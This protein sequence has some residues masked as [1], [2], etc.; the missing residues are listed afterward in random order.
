M[1]SDPQLLAK[2]LQADVFDGGP[3]LVL[4]R[5]RQGDDAEPEAEAMSYLH[6][7][8]Y[9]VPRVEH[10]D[11]PD[12]LMERVEG[13][14]M[15]EELTKRPWTLLRH[16]HLLGELHAELH[17]L[18]VPAG[19]RE[20]GGGGPSIIH[21]D[22]HPDNIILSPNGPVVIDWSNVARSEGAIDVAATWVILATA[23]MPEGTTKPM[24]LAT[25][26]GRRTFLGV[27]RRAA[28]E[29][30]ARSHLAELAELRARHPKFPE[31]EKARLRS[32]SEKYAGA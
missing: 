1:D 24:R 25:L 8:G 5:Y 4:R 27:F 32:F 20:A 11:G 9:P 18:E 7:Q 30:D 22:L 14:T 31:A 16:G 17:A 23:A 10:A 29:P 19:L 13:P 12:L 28:D 3:G 21:G 26:V 15:L 2:G 6:R